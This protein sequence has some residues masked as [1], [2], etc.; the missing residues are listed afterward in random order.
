VAVESAGD[1]VDVTGGVTGEA[2]AKRNVIMPVPSGRT[3]RLAAEQL[4]NA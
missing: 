2:A 1:A 4:L 3:L